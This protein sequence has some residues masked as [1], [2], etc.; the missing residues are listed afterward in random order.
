M[1]IAKKQ[2]ITIVSTIVLVFFIGSGIYVYNTIRSVPQMFKLNE[3][4]KSEGYYMAEFEFKMLGCIYYLDKGQYI[5]ALTSLNRIH[6]QLK[7]RDGLIKVPNF[8]NKKEKLEFYLNLQNPKTGA[9]IDDSY[10]LFTYIGCTL[11]VASYINVLSYEANEPF[12]LKYPLKFL[13]QINTPEKL[14]AF[15]DNLSTVGWIGAKFRTP[16][17]EVAELAE[18]IPGDIERLDLYTFSPEWK[19]AM[20]NWFYD[21]QDS[22]TGYWGPK[23]RGSTELLDSGDLE[24][25]EKILKLFVDNQ[26]YNL[27]SEFPLRYKDEIFKSTL[28]KLAEPMPQDLAS[29]HKWTLVMNRGTRLLTRYLWSSASNDNK[30]SARRL[31]E[32]IV[33]SKFEETYIENEGAF[34]LYPGA[35]HADLD[36]MGETIAYLDMIGAIS[37][38]KQKL[39]WGPP[40]QKITDLGVYD[41]SKLQEKDF[42]LIK[43]S[44]GI[45]SLRLYRTNPSTDYTSDVVGIIYPQPTPVLDMVDL[46]PQVTQWL[47]TTPQNMG[48][49]V[50][51]ESIIAELAGIKIQ[52]ARVYRQDIPL[53]VANEVFQN[54]RELTVIGY[55]VLQVPICKMTL[56]MSN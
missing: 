29:V 36:G 24:A 49:W 41:I 53:D 56:R 16:Y 10:P 50:S 6:D 38:D 51:K 40:E 48:N 17:I 15:L 23:L 26:G 33:R 37:S 43:N 27:H 2:L 45:N 11:N 5:T 4:L 9:F 42:A 44:P 25:T 30:D 31:M 47:S 34:S 19:E 28:Q 7:T 21:N 54:K 55:D 46:L 3:E 8:N 20:L 39:L 32:D 18:A 12:Q 14:T 13:D 1:K 22:K 52:P 35:E